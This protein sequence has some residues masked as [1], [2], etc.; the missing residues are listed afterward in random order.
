MDEKFNLK[1][2]QY[3]L[4]ELPENEV[5]TI[6]NDPELL[7]EAMRLKED[8]ENFF[9]KFDIDK[10]VTEAKAKA[11]DRK[12]IQF[13]KKSVAI[14]TTVAACFAFAITLLP[15]LFKSD[16]EVI[17][18]KGRNKINIYQQEGDSINKLS[19]LD[20]V[21]ENDKL[22]ITYS[23]TE[24]YGIIFS[25]DGL[26]NITYHYPENI[27][28]SRSM[29]IGSDISLPSSYILDN[30]PYF[31]KFYLVTSKDSFDFDYVNRNIE[32]MRVDNGSLVE[33]LELSADYNIKS[34]TLLKD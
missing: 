23:S 17:L 24:G 25:I 10:L 31:E 14:L 30:A 18:L 1:L 12:I 15:G 9:N 27:Y 32:S 2:E 28:G 19:N 4:G 20:K 33:D 13:P 29:D 21:E 16:E 8:N 5:K 3:I 6:E 7:K 11:N 22:Q 26:N 34:I